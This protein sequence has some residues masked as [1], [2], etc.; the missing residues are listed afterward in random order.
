MQNCNL[1]KNLWKIGFV[2]HSLHTGT[3][4]MG[5]KQQKSKVPESISKEDIASSP[6]KSGKDGKVLITISAKPGAKVSGITEVS[7]VEYWNINIRTSG[8]RGG[9]HTA[10]QIFVTGFGS[11]KVWFMLRVWKSVQIKSCFSVGC[12]RGSGWNNPERVCQQM[13]IG[14][15]K[16]SIISKKKKDLCTLMWWG[17][18]TWLVQLNIQVINIPSCFSD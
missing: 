18:C 6:L 10:S 15:K 7:W 14:L 16:K 11:E 12:E 5:K 9:Q 1:I 4:R 13:N 3:Y 17:I 2:Q 8:W